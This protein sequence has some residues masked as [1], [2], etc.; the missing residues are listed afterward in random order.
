MK[1]NYRFWKT[2]YQEYTENIEI[3]K[4]YFICPGSKTFF[5]AWSNNK[6][7]I[8]NYVNEIPDINIKLKKFGTLSKYGNLILDRY[9]G[10]GLFDSRVELLKV[11]LREHFVFSLE[12]WKKI[13]TLYL[14]E[15]Y[16]AFENG[17]KNPIVSQCYL[18]SV[19]KFRKE[20]VEDRER[21]INLFDT[22]LSIRKKKKVRSSE[23]HLIYGHPYWLNEDH[24]KARLSF[25]KWVIKEMESLDL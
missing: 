19:H 25:L 24:K 16:E 2:V 7:K 5:K 17:Y 1:L 6:I 13:K 15:S 20:W 9:P 18:C 23:N 12:E 8:R 4:Y 11:I 22:Y 3:N 14:D 10:V 21:F